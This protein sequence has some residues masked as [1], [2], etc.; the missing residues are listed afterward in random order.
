MHKHKICFPWRGQTLWNLWVT[1]RGKLYGAQKCSS[2]ASILNNAFLVRWLLVTLY[3]TL[4]KIIFE[5]S[6]F[7]LLV[8]TFAY[9][10]IHFPAATE[11][12]HVIQSFVLVFDT[13]QE[14]HS[15]S[16]FQSLKIAWSRLLKCNL[17]TIYGIY[18]VNEDDGCYVNTRKRI[19]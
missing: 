16:N 2:L 18:V 13:G 19:N 8:C 3:P 6:P 14:T 4:Y 9:H 5:R 7:L 15:R 17:S 12:F 11:H 10:F 1:A